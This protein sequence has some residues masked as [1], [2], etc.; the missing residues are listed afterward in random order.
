MVAAQTF[1]VNA[2]VAAWT[3][4]SETIIGNDLTE[5]QQIPR[6]AESQG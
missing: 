4:L 6:E 2:K 1:L 5:E 3:V